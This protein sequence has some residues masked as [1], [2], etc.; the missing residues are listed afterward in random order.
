VLESLGQFVDIFRGKQR[1]QIG[2]FRRI[3]AKDFNC[4]LSF[5]D[6][7]NLI[8]SQKHGDFTVIACHPFSQLL[9]RMGI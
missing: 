4:L 1:N 2:R 8:A 3:A 7:G 6:T 5:E 9:L